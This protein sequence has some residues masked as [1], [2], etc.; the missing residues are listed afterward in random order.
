[1]KKQKKIVEIKKEPEL[2]ASP[3]PP[4]K[5]I[6][7]QTFKRP[8]MNNFFSP[9]SRIRLDQRSRFFARTRRGGI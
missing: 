7:P 6:L 4:K 1:M 3:E 8:P 5:P 9:G 2:P